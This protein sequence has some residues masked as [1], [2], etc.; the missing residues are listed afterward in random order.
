VKGPTRGRVVAVNGPLVTCE[1]E[2]DREVLQNEVAYVMC[3]GVP[4]KAEVIRVRGQQIDTQVFESTV[5]L[6]VGDPVDFS[7]D[8]LSVTLGPGMLGMIYDGLQNPLKELP[9][10]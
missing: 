5:G 4:L 7:G 10:G 9:P 8:L 1:V 6:K 2:Q 3:G